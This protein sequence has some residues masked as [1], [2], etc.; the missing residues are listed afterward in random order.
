[1]RIVY[2]E[3]G[4]VP[5]IAAYSVHT[6]HTVSAMGELGHE[7]TLLAPDHPGAARGPAE[8]ELRRA[9]GLAGPFR[10]RYLPHRDR[11]ARL[12]LAYLALAPLLA[13]LGGAD[14]VFTRNPRV[15]HIATLAR[16]RVLI[17]W[18]DPPGTARTLR[19]ARRLVESPRVVRWVFVS[20][21]LREIMAGR[22]PLDPARCVVAHNGV[23]LELFDPFPS[24]EDARRALGLDPARPVVVHAGHM[25]A[26]RGID[27]LLHVASVTPRLQLVLVG[28]APEDVAAVRAEA[29]RRGIENV[30]VAGHRPVRELP[31]YLAAADVLVMPYTSATVTSD[32]R[33]RSI[34]FASPMK[35]F[36]YMAAERPIVATRFPALSEVLVDGR[37]AILVEPD[38]AEALRAG[39][40]AALAD[41]ARAARL[42]RAAR[43]E[44]EAR[45]WKKRT[46]RILAGL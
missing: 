39:I 35:A 7:V 11:P 10:L 40:E 23:A 27:L 28:G 46:A 42:A 26:G 6:L 33:T 32:R 22:L 43:E 3:E 13:R 45:T 4:W 2:I 16:L 8:D 20:E 12:R 17:E 19:L 21:R 9:T 34:E 30:V 37:N 14:L 41:P 31:A 5:S 1:M 18:H 29:R 36:E 15:A 38:S 25:Y 24:R 44:V